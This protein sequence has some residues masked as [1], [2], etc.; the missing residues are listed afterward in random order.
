MVRISFSNKSLIY[1]TPNLGF[2]PPKKYRLHKTIER[3][4]VSY[5]AINNGDI[6]L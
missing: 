6:S 2:N 1:L 3:S 4:D 5:H